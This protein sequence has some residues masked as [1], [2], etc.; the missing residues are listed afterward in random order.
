MRHDFQITKNRV[1]T[2]E[3][4]ITIYCKTY[5]QFNI[6]PQFEIQREKAEQ[7]E[8]YYYIYLKFLIFAFEIHF[9]KGKKIK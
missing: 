9:W 2:F 5:W 8:S 6:L 4:Y 7:R 1:I 3:F